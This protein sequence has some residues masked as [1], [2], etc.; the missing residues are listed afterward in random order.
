MLTKRPKSK[1]SHFKLV[2]FIKRLVV[3]FIAF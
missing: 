1:K 3:A 2:F